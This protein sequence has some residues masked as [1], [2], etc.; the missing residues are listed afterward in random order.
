MSTSVCWELTCDGLKSHPGWVKNSQPLNTAYSPEFSF[1][2]SSVIISHILY[3]WDLN[4]LLFPL[5]Q[6]KSVLY[7]KNMSLLCLVI[8]AGRV[9]FQDMCPV[10][11]LRVQWE[12][13]SYSLALHNTPYRKMTS[14]FSWYFCLSSMSWVYQKFKVKNDL[15]ISS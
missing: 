8:Y 1:L 9:C 13:F 7:F 14:P 10:H 4:A 11:F 2:A 15:F 5:T 12:G 3:I 6:T